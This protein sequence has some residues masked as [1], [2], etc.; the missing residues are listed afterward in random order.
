MIVAVL[1]RLARTLLHLVIEGWI[2]SRMHV[3]QAGAQQFPL[4]RPSKVLSVD[5]NKDTRSFFAIR[6]F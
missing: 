3:V 2:A 4:P 1:G 6:A 5:L